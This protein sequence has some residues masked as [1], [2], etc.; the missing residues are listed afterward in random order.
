MRLSVIGTFGDVTGFSLAGSPGVV[1][2]DE[3]GVAAALEAECG[4]GNVALVLMSEEA[5]GVA[6]AAIRKWQATPGAPI[7]LVLPASQRPAPVEVPE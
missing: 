6:A 3:A 7:I 1:C 2:S 5:A 4:D